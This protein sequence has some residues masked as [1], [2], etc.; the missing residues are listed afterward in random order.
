M[1]KEKK[2]DKIRKNYFL[3]GLVQRIIGQITIQNGTSKNKKNGN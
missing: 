3:N 1:Q 2:K